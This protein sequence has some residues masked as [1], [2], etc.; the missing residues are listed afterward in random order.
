MIS[1]DN[2]K[3]ILYAIKCILTDYP[4]KRDIP[5]KLPNPNPLIFTGAVTGN[6]DGSESLTVKVPSGRD[7][8]GMIGYFEVTLTEQEGGLYTGNKTFDQIKAEIEKN[9]RFMFINGY[10]CVFI[11]TRISNALIEFTGMLD[12]ADNWLQVGVTAD[13]RWKIASQIRTE[14]TKTSQLENDSRFITLTDLPVYNGEM[15]NG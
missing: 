15:E 14:I 8:N 6:Y 11:L 12:G 1:L 2:L 5:T 10:D 13:E 4:K 3:T 7:M 9:N